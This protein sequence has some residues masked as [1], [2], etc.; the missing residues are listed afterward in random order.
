VQVFAHAGRQLAIVGPDQ[1]VAKVQCDKIEVLVKERVGHLS[2]WV[3]GA[4]C[5]PFFSHP[6][7][8]TGV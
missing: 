7:K 1:G 5:L 4:P 8:R 6:V 2:S 3:D